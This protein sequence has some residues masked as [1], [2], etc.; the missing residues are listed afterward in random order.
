MQAMPHRFG[1]RLLRLFVGLV[2]FGAGARSAF[3]DVTLVPSHAL[4][5]YYDVGIDRVDAWMAIDFDDS[6]WSAGYAPLGY[7]EP[8]VITTTTYPRSTVDY[9]RYSFQLTATPAAANVLFRVWR[10]DLARVFVQ[11]QPDLR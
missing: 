9:F 4:W 7:G 5:K 10:D 11:W 8:G 6:A 3:A 2:F 1:S